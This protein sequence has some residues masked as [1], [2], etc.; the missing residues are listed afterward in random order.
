MKPAELTDTFYK[1]IKPRL[2]RRIGRELRLAARI[3]DLGCG[4][5]D[6]A[7]YLADTYHQNVTGV[8]VSS[9]AFPQSEASSEGHRIHCLRKDAEHM[10][11]LR[12]ESV[13]AVIMKWALH[14]ME[15]PNLVLREAYRVL[16]PGGQLL[17]VDFP[18]DS[19]AQKLW[20]EDYYSP[21]QVRDML[22]QAGFGDTK[23]R[24][25]EKKQIIWAVAFRQG[26]G[27]GE[28]KAG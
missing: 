9:E 17:V 16:R 24:L 25:V 21:A 4:S 20:N 8:D 19:L 5:C 2:F 26:V 14:E 28:L 12:D 23:V 3:V 22:V 1:D 10:D 13:D 6:L 7:R 18:R 27:A 11:F 15:H